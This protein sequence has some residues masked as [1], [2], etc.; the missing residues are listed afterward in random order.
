MDKSWIK[1]DKDSL[2]YEIRV[3][4]FLMYGEENYENP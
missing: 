1:E 2:E 4:K 3:E